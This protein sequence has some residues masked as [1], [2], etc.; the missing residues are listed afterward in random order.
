MT[1]LVSAK[2][3]GIMPCC[4]IDCPKATCSANCPQ[5]TCGVKGKK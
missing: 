2:D 4:F 5:L 3:N 1:Y